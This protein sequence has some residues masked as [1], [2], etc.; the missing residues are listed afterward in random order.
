MRRLLALALLTSALAAHARVV[1]LDVSSRSDLPN[2]YEK[3]TG[4]VTYALDPANPHNRVIVDLDKAPRDE[5][6]EVVFAGDVLILR[7]KSGGNDTLYLEVPN[8]GGLGGFSNPEW[9]ASLFQRGYTLAWVAWQFDVRPDPALLHFTAP[10]VHGVRGLV[11]SD[12]TVESPQPTHTIAHE[13]FA[14]Y[15]HEA[16]RS[17]GGTGYPVADR[18]DRANILTERDAVDAPRRTIARA[19]WRFTDDLTIALDGNFVPG[20]IYEFVYAAAD[21]AVAGTGLAAIRDF[22]SWARNDPASPIHVKNAYTLGIS[23]TGRFLRHFLYEG[24]NA[25]ENGRQVFDGAIIYVAGAGRGN[26]NHR[27]AQP[28]RAPI[29]PAPSLERADLFPFTDLPQTDPVTG[30]TEGLLDRAIAEK[31]VPK[32]FY[33]N[34]SY[35]YW[36]RGGSLIHT[37]PDARAD[38][39]LPPTSRI[40][41]VAGHAHFDGPFPPER[42][43]GGTELQNPVNYFNS[44]VHAMIDDL[45][46]WVKKGTEPPPSRYPRIDDGTLVRREQLAMP[47]AP[48]SVYTPYRFTSDTQPRVTGTFPTLVPQVGPDGNELAG[49]RMPF[50]TTPLAAHTG[51]NPRDPQTGFAGDRVGFAGSLFPFDKATI[52]ARYPSREVYLGRFT[53]DAL[54]LIKDRYISKDDL[55]DLLQQASQF[56]EWSA[57]RP[58]IAQ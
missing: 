49:L 44:T 18:N 12:F 17:I 52:A 6:G 19:K 26:F 9:D 46:A 24:F 34:T 28:S 31:V 47:R 30:R 16:I 1:R 42:A 29:T 54:Q 22:A 58:T 33:V 25:D 15:G 39:P 35:E 57:A 3:I 37:T 2:G 10:V 41:V 11:R 45:D 51:W 20:R 55:Y 8:R 40:Y 5:H 27:F 36:S 53:A 32:I 23:Q 4:R 56:W 43:V 14:P 7:P 48:R 50:L 38:V 21:P 13:I